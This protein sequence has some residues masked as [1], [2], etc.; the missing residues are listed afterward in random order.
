MSKNDC[1]KINLKNKIKKS[2]V[3]ER[4]Q[5]PSLVNYLLISSIL[6]SILKSKASIFSFKLELTLEVRPILLKS[7]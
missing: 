7:N 1:E 3:D 2:K 6:K 4:V 5:S